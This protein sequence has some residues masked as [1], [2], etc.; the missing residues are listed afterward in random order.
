MT[1]GKMELSKGDPWKLGAEKRIWV[2]LWSIASKVAV[3]S[4]NIVKAELN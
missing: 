2:I 4:M 3:K 1:T